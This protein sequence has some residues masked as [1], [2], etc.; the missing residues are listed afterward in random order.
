MKLQVG[1]VVPSYLVRS[2]EDSVVQV[3]A[4]S[5]PPRILFMRTANLIIAL[6]WTYIP[7]GVEE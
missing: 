1:G 6:P 7:V 5:T 3:C 2:S 4:L